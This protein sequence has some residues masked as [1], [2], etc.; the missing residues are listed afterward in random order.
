[1]KYF[2]FGQERPQE[3]S[4]EAQAAHRMNREKEKKQ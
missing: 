2:E 1:M 3:F 4:K